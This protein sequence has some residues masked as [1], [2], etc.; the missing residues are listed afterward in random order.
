MPQYPQRVQI[1]G[2]GGF[3]SK[4]N[5]AAAAVIKAVLG[6]IFSIATNNA[7]SSGNLIVNDCA[8]TGAASAANQILTLTTAQ[9]TS[10]MQKRASLRLNFPC[11]NGI[12]VSS[13]PT[14]GQFSIAFS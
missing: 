3:Q 14:G 6:T 5:V 1:L 12:T 8:T 13:M 7:G 4:I 10:L 2:I 11:L 9:L